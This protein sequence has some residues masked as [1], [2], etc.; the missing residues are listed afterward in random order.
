MPSGQS[1]Q[2]LPLAPLSGRDGGARIEVE[3]LEGLHKTAQSVGPV[4]PC[5][6]LCGED[7]VPIPPLSSLRTIG[8]A[9]DI[10]SVIAEERIEHEA[11]RMPAMIQD[12]LGVRRDV[13]KYL[14]M[15]FCARALAPDEVQIGRARSRPRYPEVPVGHESHEVVVQGAKEA[16][17]LVGSDPH[18]AQE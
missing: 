8:K 12:E 17:C 9:P 18:G 5:L 10:E 16:R 13:D 2:F 6:R 4:C 7:D 15:K 11:L 1:Q 3:P 14:V